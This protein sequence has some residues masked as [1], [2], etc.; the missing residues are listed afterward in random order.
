MQ[1]TLK[2]V[3]SSEFLSAVDNG[4]KDIED[5]KIYHIDTLWEALEQLNQ[6]DDE[7]KIVEGIN[8]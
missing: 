7:I 6:N 1:A 5:G 4:L 8:V 2:Q 3:E